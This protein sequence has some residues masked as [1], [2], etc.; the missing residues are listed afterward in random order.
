M[1]DLVMLACSRALRTVELQI[2]VPDARFWSPERPLPVRC[3][4][5]LRCR[6]PGV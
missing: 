6:K 1:K 5:L 4:G 2:P 3:Q